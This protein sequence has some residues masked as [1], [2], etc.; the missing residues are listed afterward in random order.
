[1]RQLIIPLAG[2]AVLLAGCSDPPPPRPEVTFAVDGQSV[3]ARPFQYCDVMVTTCDRDS[4]AMAKLKVPPGKVVTVTVPG[5]VAE[6][7]WSVVIQYKT[8]AGEQKD[9]E[10]VATFVPNERRDYTVTLPGAGDQLQ[11]VE[12]K[13]AGAKQ[14]PGAT[15][16]IQLLA[17]AVWSLQV[18]SS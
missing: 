16:E 11:T 17:R 14:E 7:P 18:E 15:S 12:I 3:S 13:Q 4:G 2:A 1:M 9:P 6:A 10:T 8:A 5:E